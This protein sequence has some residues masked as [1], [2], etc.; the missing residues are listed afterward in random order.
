MKF[1]RKPVLTR[2][3]A[4]DASDALGGVK[5]GCKIIIMFSSSDSEGKP[6]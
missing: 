1:L 5:K 3:T 6:S 4:G 2:K